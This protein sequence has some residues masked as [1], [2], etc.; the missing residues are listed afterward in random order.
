MYRYNHFLSRFVRLLIIVS[1][2]TTS[3]PA[4]VG[5]AAQPVPAN[6]AGAEPQSASSVERQ[7]LPAPESAQE[8]GRSVE[9]G[10]RLYALVEP[11][12]LARGAQAAC[13]ITVVNE[14]VQER[15]DL[16]LNAILPAGLS[17]SQGLRG[18]KWQVAIERL[19]VGKA[20]Q[21]TLPLQAAASAAGPLEFEVQLRDAEDQLHAVTTV[22]V[23]ARGEG[24]KQA[25]STAGERFV[26]DDG[27]VRV[28]FPSGALKAP[29]RVS[30][31]VHEQRMV[32]DRQKESG[33]QNLLSWDGTLLRFSVEAHDAQTGQEVERFE[34]PVTLTLD[35][36]GL[37]GEEGLPM[38]WDPVLYYLADPE[39][40]LLEEVPARFDLQAGTLMAQ[41]EHFST[42]IAA[43]EGKGW[44]PQLTPPVPDLFSGAATY[45][46]PVKMPPGRNGLQ[47][48]I[49]LVYNSRNLDGLVTAAS[50]SNGPIGLLG[51][52]V[53]GIA[54]IV[55]STK[56]NDEGKLTVYDEYSLTVNGTS[57]E[58]EPETAGQLCGRYYAR[59]AP[60]LYVE[61]RNAAC[62]NGSGTYRTDYW[63][64]RQPD[65]TQLRLGYQE[66]SHAW[67]H[68]NAGQSIGGFCVPAGRLEY[69][70]T[71][72]KV[73]LVTDVR[74]NKI[75]FV[76]KT[77]VIGGSLSYRKTGL[78]EIRYN[79]YDDGGQEEWLSKVTFTL[80][81]DPDPTK[82]RFDTIR[83]EHAGVELR[84]YDLATEV[85][86][87]EGHG[88]FTRQRIP[89][90]IQEFSDDGAVALPATTFQ[91][92]DLPNGPHGG[93]F[94]WR[95]RAVENGY[96]G[97]TV[98]DYESDYRSV[99]DYHLPD[100]GYSYWVTE[101]R[102]YDEPGSTTPAHITRYEY[103]DPCYDQLWSHTLPEGAHN[104]QSR[105]P[106]RNGPLVGHRWVRE[107]AYD[108]NQQDALVRTSHRYYT[109]NRVATDWW[110]HGREYETQTYSGQ[111]ELLNR[112][113]TT[114]ANT[115][116]GGLD[117]F[118]VYVEEIETTD[119]S[120]SAPM[121]TRVTFE[122]DSA[123]QGGEQYGNLTESI[124]YDQDDAP[125]R[126]TRWQYY[127][128][129]NPWIVAKPG[130]ENI[131]RRA[132]SAWKLVASTWYAYDGHP[133][134]DHAIDGVGELSAVRR[135][136]GAFPGD[137]NLID[138]YYTYDAWGN[139]TS[140][141]T[142]GGYGEY[143]AFASAA[144]RTMSIEYDDDYHL[145]PLEACN[146][147]DDCTTTEYYGVDGVPADNGP[148]GQVRLVT[149]PNDAETEYWYDDFGR[150]TR[151]WLPG[152]NV[153]D[154]P[155]RVIYYYDVEQPDWY[156]LLIVT[157]NK[158]DSDVTWNDFWTGVGNVWT[159]KFYDGLG[160]PIQTQTRASDWTPG[161]GSG[162]HEIVQDTFYDAL[163]QV[164]EQS[165][166]YEVP[167]HVPASPP[168]NPYK[169]PD[170]SKPRTTTQYDALGRV[171][172]VD[173]PDGTSTETHY[174]GWTT[175][176]V[177]ANGHQRRYTNDA[178]GRLEKVQEFEGTYPNATL[179][180]TTRY[181]YDVLGNLTAVT[182]E[183]GNVTTM[184]Y[185]PLSR[186]ETMDD[187]DMG[188]WDYQY[189]A[190]GNLSVQDDAKGQ[191]I[192]FYYDE[193]N[194]LVGKHYTNDTTSCPANN[195]AYYDVSYVYDCDEYGGTCPSG[196]EGIGRRTRMEDDSGVTSWTYDQRGR[197]TAQSKTI[198]GAGTFVTEYTHDAADRVVTMAYPDGETVTHDYN[199]RGLLESLDGDDAYVPAI[200][201]NAMGQLK[202]VAYGNDLETRY[203]YFG[204]EHYG[205]GSDLDL[206][207]DP[208]WG[209]T[210][211]G[212]LMQACTVAQGGA[213]PFGA[214]SALLNMSYWYDPAGN[215][216]KIRDRTNG[217]QVQTFSYDDLGRLTRAETDSLGQGT[218]DR[219][220]AYD[221]IGNIYSRQGLIYSYAPNHPHAVTSVGGPVIGTVASYSYDANGN[222]TS[223]TED[224]DSYTQVFNIENK[225][226]S[227][228]V[229][230]ETTEFVYDG[231]GN[232]VLRT[233]PDGTQTAYVGG[234]YEKKVGVQA[235]NVP[236][237][238]FES[239]G[240]W[241]GIR[242]SAYPGTSF[243]R[244]TWG[245]ANE[246]SG[247]RAY[248]TSN[249]AYGLLQSSAIAVSP[250]TQ[251]DLYA[252]VR[253]ELDAEDSGGNWVIRARFY[254]SSGA[255]ISYQNAAA[256]GAG[257]LSTTWQSKGGRITTPSNAA[258]V[259]IQLYN[260][261]NSGWVAYDDV[262]F[263]EVDNL[264]NLAPNPGFE[265]S[266]SW[267]ERKSSVFP[268]TSLYRSTWGTAA[269][270]GGSYAYAIS[271]H[272]Y[273]YLQS[274]NITVQPNVQYNLRAYV[275]GELDPEGSHGGGWIIRARFYNSSG[276]SIGYQNAASGGAGSLNT[277]WQL[278]GGT[279]TAPATAAYARVELY[280]Y[281]NT[282]WV[283]FD[284]VSLIERL[285][286]LGLKDAK[287]A[288]GSNEPVPEASGPL[289]TPTPI[290]IPKNLVP[291]PGFESSGSWTEHRNADFP[292]TSF[293][294]GKSGVADQHSGS[295]GY[296][297]SNLAYG[298]LQSDNIPVQPNQVYELY[299]YLRGELDPEDSHGGGWIIRAMFY[300]GG[301]TYIGYQ[302]A[303]S[304]G[305]GSLNTSWRE[306][307]GAVTAPAN[308]ASLR[309]RLYNYY[310]SG[311]VAFDDVRLMGAAATETKYYY[312][313]GQRV[314]MRVDDGSTDVV[315]YL[316][317]DHLGST[318]L[319]T[320][321]NGVEV[322]GSRT[323]YYPYGEERWS[324]SGGDLPTDYGFTGQRQ[325]QELGLYDYNA[326]FYDPW[327][328]R[329]ISADT[330]LPEPENPQALNRYSYV[331]NNPLRYTD[332][333][334]H[335]ADPGGGNR[336]DPEDPPDPLA[337]TETD[338]PDHPMRSGNGTGLQSSQMVAPSIADFFD[339][340]A[341]INSPSQ[342]PGIQSSD[343]YITT[344]GD[345]PAIEPLIVTPDDPMYWFYFPV[346]ICADCKPQSDLEWAQFKVLQREAAADSGV[347]LRPEDWGAIRDS[348]RVDEFIAHPGRMMQSPDVWKMIRGLGL[349]GAVMGSKSNEAY[350]NLPQ[351][352][353]HYG[354]VDTN[355]TDPGIIP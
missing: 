31:R 349:G 168:Q 308:A 207:A 183:Q 247:S 339:P 271:N 128:S 330:I 210:S 134:F 146:A 22:L 181:A 237:P 224:G 143:N 55:R 355:F 169:A 137:Q 203:G 173:S 37:V 107:T 265:S 154:P 325:E 156:P 10:M 102:S 336:R 28:D 234:Y 195:P 269:P 27:R 217:N 79:N 243:W 62:G 220:Y 260:Y 73:D 25:L 30:A 307:G 342:A 44:E 178:F 306:E 354:P 284:D 142:Y 122:Y 167:R 331:L 211:F 299:S 204:Y 82:L 94:Y 213:C 161:G 323:L 218:Y 5:R 262:S 59:N 69:C 70:A 34:Q 253:G 276:S 188:N 84:R 216:T 300:D 283:A 78:E 319:A 235:L 326:R 320:D 56:V 205:I 348:G 267:S 171:V 18:Q 322:P 157:Y 202:R 80:E 174:A 83:V 106:P 332:P 40:G 38:G 54:G 264:F 345:I 4:S 232:R 313:A 87:W 344:Q 215:V 212:R 346:D 41:L 196:N 126:R 273:G 123:K 129:L 200:E 302:N 51:W 117:N 187:P 45:Q 275:R 291:N 176:A 52:T 165:A 311:W 321:E 96:G 14:D 350:N 99:G 270:H 110:L 133:Q 324:A 197:V 120:G 259:R 261:L 57:H 340:G 90:S 111:D 290:P 93:Y 108:F 278:K 33:R 6:D 8:P 249:H 338:V 86:R 11:G 250:N 214:S 199:H 61:R 190:A 185:D 42:Y 127:P 21:V 327:L 98:F 125:Y 192:C 310:N 12:V 75:E 9:P 158:T 88:H 139:R 256:G 341:A 170:L 252:Y 286:V 337:S 241:S 315:S 298:Y 95:L 124:E 209:A 148:P 297:I 63:I 131:D 2:L 317:G 114:W 236:N 225:L 1:I 47:P 206:N 112:T 81:H 277:T 105:R 285:S 113:D 3:L 257:S 160:R 49:S 121:S 189:D 101:V 36:R 145:Y 20:T 35:L 66:T 17:S 231:D 130:Y 150:L 263:R 16:T 279:V 238:G 289:P 138:T 244:G 274:A 227:V 135:W 149:D 294:R 58:L 351:V 281:L 296:A 228:S 221:E 219:S 26:S 193:L 140:E 77:K 164:S 208:S 266:G 92:Q 132:G 153:N 29:V 19:A 305:A 172:Q 24:A 89:L 251:Y 64:V 177:D 184:E 68:S 353:F 295:Y 201:Y 53:G 13:T 147:L 287:V 166:P 175:T 233:K 50:V 229:D 76:H 268:G 230:S 316:H 301:G 15:D 288:S 60:S 109:R 118:F 100:Y 23:G 116:V 97:K 245:T 312:A 318:T 239:S 333:T 292:G 7:A 248:A 272:A 334:G 151:V 328:G 282:G 309:I 141:T 293:H 352:Y 314:A 32:F 303:A 280:N 304:G 85:R 136:R 258:S 104:C 152:E 74:D 347:I 335:S 194:R 180:A 72:W 91:H 159:R 144:P 222:M 240:N 46:Y 103:D 71:G 163:G 119:Y 223:R 155:S 115:D 67:M 246:H 179:Y 43:A 162:Q 65:G 226:E 191:R 182:D 343:T 255:Y 186:K 39:K 242:S 329:F 254:N 198:D 48:Q